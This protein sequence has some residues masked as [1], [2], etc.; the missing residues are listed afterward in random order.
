[1][2]S[3]SGPNLA[4]SG[5]GS[6]CPA[7]PRFMPPFS[8]CVSGCLRAASSRQRSIDGRFCRGC[9]VVKMNVQSIE[10]GMDTAALLAGAQ[11][12]D[13]FRIRVDDA[14][15]GARLAAEKMLTRN[16]RWIEVLMRLRNRLAPPVGPEKPGPAGAAPP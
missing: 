4:R 3:P 15:L 10:P 2:R 5:S 13:A 8:S 12:A 16:P 6:A 9:R 11:F 7:G 14:A 1:M